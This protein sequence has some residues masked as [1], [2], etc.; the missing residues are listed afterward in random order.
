MK[1]KVKGIVDN[2]YENIVKVQ[3]TLPNGTGYVEWIEDDSPD[4]ELLEEIETQ[5][6]NAN[7]ED[8]SPTQYCTSPGDISY[9]GSPPSNHSFEDPMPNQSSED[10]CSKVLYE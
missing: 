9:H 4:L 10:I 8:T 7:P 2:V 3:V 1:K 5:E 6:V